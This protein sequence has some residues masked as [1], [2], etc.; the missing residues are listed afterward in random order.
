MN[1]KII[2]A[3]LALL[4]IGAGCA[5][6]AG[7][8]PVSSQSDKAADVAV[9][10][11]VSADAAHGDD[12]HHVSKLA[13]SRISLDDKSGLKPG[14]VSLR[15]KLYGLDGHEFG[16]GDLQV[17][18]EKKMHLLLVRDDM[19]GFQH[20]HPEHKDGKW[21]VTTNVP[22]AGLYQMYVDIDPEEEEPI[23]LRVPLTIGGMTAKKEFPTP[24]ADHSATSDG[25]KVVLET[26]GTIKSHEETML[27]FVVTS[28]GKPVTAIGPYLGAY[29]H[30]VLLRHND[31][32]DFF[33]VHPVTETKPDDGRVQFEA[34]FPVTGSYTLYAQFNLAG[35][36]RTF[37]VTVEVAE[38]SAEA[39]APHGHDT[40]SEEAPAAGGHHE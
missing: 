22:E 19:T 15:F 13:G 2:I 23:V 14:E 10:D 21:A 28:G 31:P 27:T 33:H 9:S 26:D 7:Q 34:T 17:Q 40:D 32:D 25:F 30:V 12:E 36:V 6:Q 29:G 4:L 38:E 11:K 5:P 20:L 8:S 18:H 39:D 37:P 16:P 3:S 35:N 1:H 24:N